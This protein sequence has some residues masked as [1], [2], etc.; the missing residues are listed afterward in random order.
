MALDEWTP[1]TLFAY[2]EQRFA[3]QDRAVSA[4]LAANEKRLDGMNEFR[5]TLKDQQ[6]TY[7]TRAEVYALVGGV[8]ALAAVLGLLFAVVGHFVK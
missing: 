5:T 4:A 6:G 8:G 2:F 7:I 1:A 3:A